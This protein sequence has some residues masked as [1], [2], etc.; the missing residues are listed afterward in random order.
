[1]T[2][3]ASTKPVVLRGQLGNGVTDRSAAANQPKQSSC[4][5]YTDTAQPINHTLPDND[6]FHDVNGSVRSCLV[7]LGCVSMTQEQDH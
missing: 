4:L 1:M 6:A 5:T 2:V 7:D 3:V